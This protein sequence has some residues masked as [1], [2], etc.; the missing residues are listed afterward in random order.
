M[1]TIQLKF[2]FEHE[3]NQQTARDVLNIMTD[4]GLVIDK[5][6][7]YEPINTPFTNETFLKW[8]RIG[9]ACYR[10]FY[11]FYKIPTVEIL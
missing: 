6:G 9:T 2:H 7:F 11:R 1:N 10:L 3:T 4:Y 8:N 5:L